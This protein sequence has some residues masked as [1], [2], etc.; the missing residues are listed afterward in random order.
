MEIYIL[1]TIG[2]HLLKHPS[3]QVFL[4]EVRAF[5]IQMCKVQHYIMSMPHLGELQIYFKI[6]VMGGVL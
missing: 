2:E 6:K 3:L 1:A 4:L 5:K